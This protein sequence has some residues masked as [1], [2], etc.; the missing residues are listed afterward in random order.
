ME[1][2][3]FLQMRAEYSFQQLAV[4]VLIEDVTI[5]PGTLK[6]AEKQGQKRSLFVLSLFQL[7]S[8]AQLR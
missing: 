7:Y 8:A 2:G 4:H 3:R 6:S 5:K 1:L